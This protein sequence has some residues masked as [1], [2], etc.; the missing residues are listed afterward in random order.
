MRG[1]NAAEN[2]KL[3]LRLSL[4]RAGVSIGRDPY[5]NRVARLLDHR[6]ITTVLDVGAN[7]GQFARMIRG[8]GF[9]GDIM[10]FEPLSDAYRRLGR[11]SRRDDRWQAFNLAVGAE[12]GHSTIHV[13]DNSYSSS[14][15]AMT[16]RHLKAAPGSEIVGHQEVDVT[17]VAQIVDDHEIDPSRTFLK[18][19]TQGFERAVIA[20]AGPLI[21]DLAAVQLELSFVELYEGQELF[22]EGVE[23]MRKHGLELWIIEP[24]ISD[25]NGR[26]LQCDGLFARQEP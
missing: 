13:S 11:R 7:V 16:D 6:G 17:T 18:V 2:A 5:V 1:G 23:T 25:A 10:S 21:D 9:T 4:H 26:M 8:A 19:D 22:D 20:G 14:L 3:G 15:L 24:G 12:R